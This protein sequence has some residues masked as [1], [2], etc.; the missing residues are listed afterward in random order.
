MRF[1]YLAAAA[2]AAAEEDEDGR[3]KHPLPLCL[4]SVMAAAVGEMEGKSR[5]D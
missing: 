3:E 5:A 4:P 2:A 1:I